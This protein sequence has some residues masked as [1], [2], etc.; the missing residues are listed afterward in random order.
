MGGW[1]HHV[2]QT[3]PVSVRARSRVERIDHRL[4]RVPGVWQS[5]ARGPTAHRGITMTS[6]GH[7]R[8]PAVGRRPRHGTRRADRRPGG[9]VHALGPHLR[10]GGRPRFQ[11]ARLLLLRTGGVLGPVGA[12]VVVH[13]LGFFAARQRPHAVGVRP[14]GHWTRTRPRGILDLRVPVGTGTA[15]QGPA[16]RASGRA[17]ARLRRN[18]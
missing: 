9:T 8:D 6:N 1:E 3:P 5:A 2:Q 7:G 16:V 17:H 12:E 13:E 10:H 14:R 4:R 18:R 11:R 15:A